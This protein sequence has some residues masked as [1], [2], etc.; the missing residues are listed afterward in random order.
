[1]LQDFRFF[2][3]FNKEYVLKSVCRH[4]SL[5]YVPN[6]IYSFA[7][8]QKRAMTISTIINIHPGKYVKKCHEWYFAEIHVIKVHNGD[9]FLIMIR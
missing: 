8:V 1:M 3:F 5:T 9:V 2:A 7:I 6:F 4:K